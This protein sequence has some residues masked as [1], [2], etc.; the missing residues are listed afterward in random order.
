MLLLTFIGQASRTNGNQDPDEAR[1]KWEQEF[2]KPMAITDQL[3]PTAKLARRVAIR[4]KDLVIVCDATERARIAQFTGESV[5]KADQAAVDRFEAKLRHNQSFIGS[6]HTGRLDH[7]KDLVSSSAAAGLGQGAFSED[8]RAS[9]ALGDLSST[10]REEMEGEGGQEEEVAEEDDD[11]VEE[12]KEKDKEKD[13]KDEVW[14]G[15]DEKVGE[16]LLNHKNGW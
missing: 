6:A 8:A 10:F 11:P 9:A 12:P 16:M 4:I 14:F 7:T 1:H 5:K 15:R 3:G 2:S 13:K